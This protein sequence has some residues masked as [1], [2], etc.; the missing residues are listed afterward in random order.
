MCLCQV[1]K[2]IYPEDNREGCPNRDRARVCPTPGG[3]RWPGPWGHRAHRL[4]LPRTPGC[5]TPTN[6]TKLNETRRHGPRPTH[7]RQM[8]LE[9][10]NEG[11]D[12]GT[13]GAR[14]EAEGTSWTAGSVVGARRKL[15][16]RQGRILP[17]LRCERGRA[18]AAA[19]STNS[20]KGC[21]QMPLVIHVSPAS[22]QQHPLSDRKSVV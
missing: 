20:C 17:S 19:L 15:G 8:C 11:F 1:Y 16:C 10:R 22:C 14:S 13:Q 5:M 4:W 3:L 9:V 18:D 6:H 2:H 7:S 12:G 21:I